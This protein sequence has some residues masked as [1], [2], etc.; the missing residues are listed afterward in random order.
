MPK[1]PL[2]PPGGPAT[3]PASPAAAPFPAKGAPPHLPRCTPPPPPPPPAARQAKSIKEGTIPEQHAQ[4]EQ[5]QAG[6]GRRPGKSPHLLAPL[7]PRVGRAARHAGQGGSKLPCTAP[8]SFLRGGSCQRHSQPAPAAPL[9][10]GRC[11]RRRPWGSSPPPPQKI[12]KCCFPLRGAGAGLA[13]AL[14]SSICLS[15]ASA[16]FSISSWDRACGGGAGRR[17]GV[18]GFLGGS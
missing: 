14:T 18:R 4:L 17:G 12:T 10:G 15:I 7:A 3:R 16:S 13:E 11:C 6:T 8:A 2:V 9:T 1:D 5:V